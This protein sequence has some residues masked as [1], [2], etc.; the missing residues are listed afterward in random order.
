MDLSSD[1]VNILEIV[2][3]TRTMHTLGVL[4]QVKR[5]TQVVGGSFDKEEVL[6][7]LKTLENK[8]LLRYLPKIESW[9]IT[10]EGTDYI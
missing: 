5:M 3:T 9:K 10:E 4:D 2:G 8:G 7:M 6:S 1:L